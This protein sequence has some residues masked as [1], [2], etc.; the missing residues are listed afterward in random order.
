MTREQWA[1]MT[2]EEKRIKV[3]ELCG[4]HCEDADVVNDLNVMHEAENYLLTVDQQQE[5]VCRLATRFMMSEMGLTCVEP[6]FD[7]DDSR[8]CGAC[9]G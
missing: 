9:H 7:P 2:D 8:D 6:K 4:W 1:K 5:Y 3:A